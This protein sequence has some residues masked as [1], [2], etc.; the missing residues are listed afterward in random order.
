M[1]LDFHISNVVYFRLGQRLKNLVQL[2]LTFCSF[3]SFVRPRVYL[4]R[5]VKWLSLILFT[6]YGLL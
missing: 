3:T 4:H 1:V 2:F 6:S 5:S